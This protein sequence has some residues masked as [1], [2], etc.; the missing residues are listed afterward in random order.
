MLNHLSPI[1]PNHVICKKIYI[2][3]H[4]AQQND[5]AFF[6]AKHDINHF[7]WSYTFFTA[8]LWNIFTNE[9]TL[10]VKQVGFK[11]L[12]RNLICSN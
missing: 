3:W 9:A 8:Y 5:T 4:T 2:T 1:L 11:A 7:T 6:L 12:V 10:D